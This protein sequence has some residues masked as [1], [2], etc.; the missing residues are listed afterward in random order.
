M[1][2][3][4]LEGAKRFGLRLYLHDDDELRVEGKVNGA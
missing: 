3:Q 4:L 1:S 2:L